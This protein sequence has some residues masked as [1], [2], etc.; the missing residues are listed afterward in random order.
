MNWW[1]PSSGHWLR[2]IQK[3]RPSGTK[4]KTV[5]KASAGSTQSSPASWRR[6]RQVRPRRRALLR[7]PTG[8]ATA[9]RR[10]VKAL[11]RGDDRLR[12]RLRGVLRRLDVAVEDRVVDH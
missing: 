3:S 12:L 2:D 10:S 4:K 6:R 5:V 7:S 9:A 1:S 8:T 11:S